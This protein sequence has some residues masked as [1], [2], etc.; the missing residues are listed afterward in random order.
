MIISVL[1]PTN[2]LKVQNGSAHHGKDSYF[3]TPGDY[4]R[5]GSLCSP[6]NGKKRDLTCKNYGKNRFL[7]EER[8]IHR[9]KNNF[10]AQHILMH[11]K[12]P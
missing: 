4:A 1:K 6:G 11:I 8:T 10:E 9:Q 3:F 2:N 5:I 7:F 12:K